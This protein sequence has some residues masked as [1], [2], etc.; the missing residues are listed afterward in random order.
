MCQPTLTTKERLNR[1][2]FLGGTLTV[3]T[4]AASLVADAREAGWAGSIAGL[5]DDELARRSFRFRPGDLR[6]DWT[7]LENVEVVVL[8]FWMAPRLRIETL[9]E[10]ANS[11]LFS[12]GSWR[13]LTWSFGY[14]VDNVVQ[15]LATGAFKSLA[16]GRSAIRKSQSIIV[17]EPR[18][19]G[20]WAE[21][22]K[23]IYKA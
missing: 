15:G 2:Q 21:L 7:N 17:Y 8:Q 5:K 14:Y 22:E 10:R 12:G 23:K 6:Q 9:D 18:E 11:V 13:P 19:S 1:R 20:R 16:E 3:T 4:S